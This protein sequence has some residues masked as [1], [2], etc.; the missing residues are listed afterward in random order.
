M[1]KEKQGCCSIGCTAIL[2]LLIS[3]AVGYKFLIEPRLDRG[4]L[5]EAI[6]INAALE[7]Q[8]QV[9]DEE[10]KNYV[11]SHIATVAKTTQF[12]EGFT[13]LNARRDHAAQTP[14]LAKVTLL[15][16]EEHRILVLRWRSPSPNF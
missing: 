14:L 3:V 6:Q 5:N 9:V 8:Q 15:T 10:F 4:L 13:G 7:K 2:V 12:L 11:D 16:P 1:P